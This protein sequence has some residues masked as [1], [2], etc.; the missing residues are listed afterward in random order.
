MLLL[1]VMSFIYDQ[2]Y[3]MAA[4]LLT[5]KGFLARVLSPCGVCMFSPCMCVLSEFSHCPK[6]YMLGYLMT[7]DHKCKT[8]PGRE[9]I[10]DAGF[11]SNHAGGKESLSHVSS[12]FGKK[13]MHDLVVSL[14]HVI[15]HVDEL[16]ILLFY[17]P[18]QFF[19]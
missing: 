10:V 12:V 8:C 11:C 7:L 4:W 18:A 3:I 1:T 6:T 14:I 16:K 2:L 9:Q 17:Y 5:A 15:N 13:N 19:S